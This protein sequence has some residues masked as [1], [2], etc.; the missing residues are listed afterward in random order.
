MATAKQVDFESMNDD[1]LLKQEQAMKEMLEKIAEAK[2][3]R[4]ENMKA[5]AFKEI[6][7]VLEKY[8]GS[9]IT[10]GVLTDW[11]DD[12]QY[13][14]TSKFE[15]VVEVKV[16]GTAVGRRKIDDKDVLFSMGYK[17]K[18]GIREMTYKLDELSKKPAP[19]SGTSIVM[20]NI[21]TKT[22]EE[23]KQFFKPKFE[24]FKDTENGKK[25]VKEFFPA[26]YD[27]IYSAA[28]EPE[29]KEFFNDK[30]VEVAQD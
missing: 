14:V 16:A 12:N 22:F 18:D 11:L 6:G 27:A 4:E 3:H 15:K 19:N 17:G 23:I 24:E 5:T 10:E 9:V 25:W 21:K 13:L 30:P 28:V 26:Q 20:N 29:V 8:V 7:A 1:D 2:R